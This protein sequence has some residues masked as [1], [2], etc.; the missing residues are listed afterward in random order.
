MYLSDVRTQKNSCALFHNFNYNTYCM[1]IQ[2]G[3]KDIYISFVQ[4]IVT[5]NAHP[6]N[7]AL[8]EI[9][10]ISAFIKRSVNAL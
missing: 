6:R 9:G 2:Y 7:T 8:G 1:Q 4:I 5:D 3:T 10:F